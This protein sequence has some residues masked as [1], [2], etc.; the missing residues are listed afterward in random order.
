MLL[1]KQFKKYFAYVCA[2]NS[3]F[4]GGK[5]SIQNVQVGIM[6]TVS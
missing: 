3:H 5:Y 2:R 4:L 6:T 1:D